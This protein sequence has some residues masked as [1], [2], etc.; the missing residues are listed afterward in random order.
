[1]SKDQFVI[2][3]NSNELGGNHLWRRVAR[4][5]RATLL[6]LTAPLPVALA[7]RARSATTIDIGMRAADTIRRANIED[8]QRPQ[9]R[10]KSTVA[11]S[12]RTKPSRFAALY[13]H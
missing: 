10:C 8:E 5:W 12:I 4:T 13:F 3:G 1:M 7:E 9:E 6:R 11:I 2:T